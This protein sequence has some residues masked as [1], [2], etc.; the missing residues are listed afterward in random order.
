LFELVADDHAIDDTIYILGKALN[1]GKLD[2]VAFMKVTR[3]LAVEQFMRRALVAK[4][5]KTIG[6]K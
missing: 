4:I 1:A 3:T 2:I 5:H 6:L